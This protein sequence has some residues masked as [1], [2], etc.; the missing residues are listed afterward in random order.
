[1]TTKTKR[2]ALIVVGLLGV[3]A[4]LRPHLLPTLGVGGDAPTV[5]PSA[6]VAPA[7]AAAPEPQPP[8]E[9]SPARPSYTAEAQATRDPMVSLLPAE[10]TTH[11]ARAAGQTPSERKPG[12]PQLPAL[13]V[14]GI[15]WGT[16]RPQALINGGLYEVGDAVEGA[17]I[18]SI[19]RSG[20]TIIEVG[21]TRTVLTPALQGR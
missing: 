14:Q 11:D 17:R 15:V 13:S 7:P 4:V 20:V 5:V 21:G 19:E 2:D 9:A 8:V 3:L 6:M 18:L 10:P 12:R 16:A 1:M